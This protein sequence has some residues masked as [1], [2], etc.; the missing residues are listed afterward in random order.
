MP[1]RHTE[2]RT[3]KTERRM[4]TSLY[5]QPRWSADTDA[6]S[7][8]G[9]GALGVGRS[10]AVAIDRFIGRAILG[11][12]NT[13]SISSPAR[14]GCRRHQAID[15]SMLPNRDAILSAIGV[16]GPHGPVS[17]G[18][19]AC[20]ERRKRQ[21]RLLAR[22]KCFATAFDGSSQRKNPSL[23]TRVAQLCVWF[24]ICPLIGSWQLQAMKWEGEAPAEPI[25]LYVR[26]DGSLALPK[27]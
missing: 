7:R 5:L 17:T 19:I 27:S 3:N 21:V 13:G 20:K 14:I 11:G 24:S 4:R 2:Q 26:L 6:V 12:A 22:G 23:S 9:R 10:I 1:I 8:L 16:I 25:V 18:C 15:T